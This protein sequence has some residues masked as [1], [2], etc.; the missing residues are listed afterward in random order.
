MT[1][2]CHNKTK[3]RNN[4]R[5]QLFRKLYC[6]I[7]KSFSWHF[8]LF[9]NIKIEFEL[10]VCIYENENTFYRPLSILLYIRRIKWNIVHYACQ[11][12]SIFI[13]HMCMFFRMILSVTYLLS[14]LVAKY[15]LCF[16]YLMLI[17]LGFLSF[18][19]EQNSREFALRK[20]HSHA[21]VCNGNKTY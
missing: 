8:K 2:W 5:V 11:Y 12:L 15:I 19:R 4:F 13:N 9:I 10:F 20:V 21:N 16:Q 6:S 17:Y 14:F 18:A 1:K 7:Q 3:N